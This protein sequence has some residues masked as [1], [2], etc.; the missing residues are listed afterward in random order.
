MCLFVHNFTYNLSALWN[1]TYSLILRIK[2]H[3]REKKAHTPTTTKNKKKTTT[4]TMTKRQIRTVARATNEIIHSN[5][6]CT[7]LKCG[8]M[9]TQAH[10]HVSG[11]CND[12]VLFFYAH[13]NNWR[14]F[15]SI[16]WFR[17]N[18]HTRI[19]FS[20][21]KFGVKYNLCARFVSTISFEHT[22]F[23]VGNDFNRKISYNFDF[24]FA[25]FVLCLF[26]FF[27]FNKQCSVYVVL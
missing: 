19:H 23:I 25:T 14:H 1:H 16:Y 12:L 4:T 8:S 5:F 10:A 26:L 20:C 7:H 11:G 3:E 18:T 9:Q 2:V 21:L 6:L 27:V 13:L 17:W 24:S 15:A 22:L